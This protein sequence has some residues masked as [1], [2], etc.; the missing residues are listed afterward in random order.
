VT[1]VLFAEGLLT[2]T[3]GGTIN[4]VFT[5]GSATWNNFASYAA[6]YDEFRTLGM[7][8]EYFPSNRYT[9]V[10]TTC[11]PVLGVVDR[12]DTTALTSFTNALTYASCRPL[13]LEDPWTS[14]REYRGS[15]VPSLTIKMRGV[16]EAQWL[17]VAS[18]FNAMAIKLWS[19]G[20]TAAT[21]YGLFL[22]RGMIQFRGQG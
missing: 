14:R 9:K 20:L 2:S 17:P 6:L 3:A 12:A 5:S 19:T 8:L 16:E 21:S 4:N 7:E 1:A 10:T 13:S 22:V 18:T 15:S 11:V